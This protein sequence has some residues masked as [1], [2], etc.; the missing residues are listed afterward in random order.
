MRFLQS[1]IGAESVNIRKGANG[2]RDAHAPGALPCLVPCSDGRG[3]YI[4][5]CET[6]T[7]VS[8]LKTKG[9]YQQK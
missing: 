3:F 7:P 5:S 1:V 9:I 8:P 4:R 6:D 2:Q